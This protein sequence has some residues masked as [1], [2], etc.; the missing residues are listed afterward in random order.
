V[1][2]CLAASILAG[3]LHT[4]WLLVTVFGALAVRACTP[5]TRVAWGWVVLGVA[6][7]AIGVA[8]RESS[9]ADRR[10]VARA[11]IDGGGAP[12]SLRGRVVSFPR[13]SPYGTTFALE[14]CVGGRRLRLWTRAACFDVCYGDVVDA[15]GRLSALVLPRDGSLVARGVAGMLRV[16]VDGWTPLE[17]KRGD[18]IRARVL[19][20]IHR[21]VR[22]RLS[23]RLGNDAALPL[24]LVLGERGF[25]DRATYE[26]IRRLGIMHLLA[27]SGLHL[28]TIA[29]LALIAGRRLPRV[30]TVLV[31]AAVSLY[32]GMVGEVDSLTRAYDM[33]V[34]LVA[35]RLLI[36]PVRPTDALAKTLLLILLVSPLSVLSVGL[37]LSFV[38][39]IA[40]LLALRRV[41]GFIAPPDPDAP[42]YRRVWTGVRRTV[43]VTFALSIAAQLAVAPIQLRTFGTISLAGPV[44]T[45][46]FLGPVA[47]IQL[48]AMLAAGT[49]GIPVIGHASGVVLGAVARM[50][51][52][53]AMSAAAVAPP[54]VVAGPPVEVAYYTGLLAIWIA[55]RRVAAW[56][57]GVALIVGSFALR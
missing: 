37:Q 36:R 14:S 24:A 45:V 8:A 10:V 34:L 44:A 43:A 17:R 35:A 54:L 22:T 41:R 57:I 40:V 2:W 23:R 29:G 51:A 42:P 16:R 32:V 27:L 39:T 31:L 6:C 46:M 48:L 53:A 47:L 55:P 26:A 52:R 18:P 56:V 20:P 25:V 15:R 49:S 50:T 9:R 30:R 13:T 1:V 3:V 7:C 11:V 19:W 12:V 33:V 21:A 5:G 38:A 4:R 28:G